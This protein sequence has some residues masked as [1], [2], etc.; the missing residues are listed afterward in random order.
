MIK[1]IGKGKPVARQGRKA[2][3]SVPQIAWLPNDHG[4]QLFCTPGM[5]DN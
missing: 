3:G 1:L 4:R 5:G 2:T